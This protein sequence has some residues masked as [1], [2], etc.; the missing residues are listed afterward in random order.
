MTV[1]TRPNGYLERPAP[2]SLADVINT[3]LDK[4]LVLDVYLRVSLLGIEILTI[5]ARAVVASVDTY[6]RFAEQVNRLDLGETEGDVMDLW[7]GIN[8]TG[9]RLKTRGA[10]D[11][12]VD[13]VSDWLSPGE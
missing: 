13:K 5:D 2:S 12:A 6:L 8:R 4:G 3:I 11:R 1:A 7:E 9:A 10:I